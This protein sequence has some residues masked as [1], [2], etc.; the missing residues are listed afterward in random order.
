M[1]GL[2]QKGSDADLASRARQGDGEAWG[3]LV[4]RYA[5]YVD[6]VLRAARTPEADQADA[7]QHVFLELFKALPGLKN[8][9]SL[10]PWLRKTALRHGIRLREKAARQAPMEDDAWINQLASSEDAAAGLEEADRDQSVREAVSVLT[11]RCQELIRALFYEDP[12]RPYTEV[13]EA[14]GIKTSSLSMTRQRCLD[15]LEQQLRKLG[16][17]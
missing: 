15:A 11:D 6:A 14:L 17:E 7:F 8:T 2:P 13:A 9:E 4:E 16:V 1:V 3:R 10:S 12:P 5:S